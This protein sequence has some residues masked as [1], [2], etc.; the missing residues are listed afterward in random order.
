MYVKTRLFITRT[1]KKCLVGYLLNNGA[2]IL[3]QAAGGCRYGYYAELQEQIL[4]DL[5]YNFTIK[6][7]DLFVEKDGYVFCL[8]IFDD[9]KK[10]EWKLGKPFIRKYTFMLDQDGKT[11]YF[12]SV[13]DEV[14]IQ[15]VSSA[16]LIFMIFILLLLFSF[17]GFIL[18]RKIYRSKFKKQANVFEDTFEYNSSDVFKNQKRGSEIEMKNKLVGE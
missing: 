6:A 12:Y 17:L 18:G 11:L 1:I 13:I 15:G 2:N 16:G 8:M 5:N 9:Y 3:L 7:D 14:K 4:K 10:Y